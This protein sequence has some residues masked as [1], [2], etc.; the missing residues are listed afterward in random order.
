[1][2]IRVKVSLSIIWP[3]NK[4][5]LLLI[6]AVGQLFP[7]EENLSMKL[8]AKAKACKEAAGCEQLF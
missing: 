4:I 3:K 2:K 5:S 7:I 6:K 8:P 1:M